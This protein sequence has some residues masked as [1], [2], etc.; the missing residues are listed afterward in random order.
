MHF[1]CLHLTYAHCER[2]SSLTM[3]MN[4]GSEPTSSLTS[5]IQGF[6]WF[7]CDGHCDELFAD[8]DYENTWYKDPKY[9]LSYQTIISENEKM[10]NKIAH[11]TGNWSFTHKT[12]DGLKQYH[13]YKPSSCPFLL[14]VNVKTMASSKND[15][16]PPSA[17]TP[18]PCALFQKEAFVYYNDIWWHH[19]II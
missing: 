4:W 14:Y 2:V 8:Q 19:S 7:Q 18:K 9:H 10:E 6:N 15:D 16:G 11:P 3:V 12:P 17:F 5:H 13:Y 1:W